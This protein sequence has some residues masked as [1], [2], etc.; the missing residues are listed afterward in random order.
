MPERTGYEPY[1]SRKREDP[2]FLIGHYVV[3]AYAL[4][5]PSRD[6]EARERKKSLVVDSLACTFH[7][8]HFNEFR[9]L[10]HYALRLDLGFLDRS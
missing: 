8:I 3:Y 2:N 10:F 7:E 9:R 5:P 1:R 6:T 4:I